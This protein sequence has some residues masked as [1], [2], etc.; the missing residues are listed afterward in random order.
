VIRENG[1]LGGGGDLGGPKKRVPAHIDRKIT[2]I[3]KKKRASP[4]TR[5]RKL[6]K[7]GEKEI[8]GRVRKKKKI[9]RQ[10]ITSKAQTLESHA[11]ED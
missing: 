2:S 10:Q 5:K 3:S 8:P 6:T 4:T 1:R 9:G 7:R 11:G